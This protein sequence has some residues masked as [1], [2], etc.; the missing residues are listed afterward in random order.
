VDSAKATLHLRGDAQALS[1]EEKSGLDLFYTH[2][3][4]TCHMGELLG[5]KSF[6]RLGRER[7][8]FAERGGALTDADRGRSNVTMKS[9]DTH[10]FKVPTLRNIARTSPYFHD[11]REEGDPGQIGSRLGQDPARC[12]CSGPGSGVAFQRSKQT[13]IASARH[14]P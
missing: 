13:T 4:E 3:C 8:Y 14:L 6:E 1:A 7:D 2:R 9:R 11:G 5:G 10:S 12:P